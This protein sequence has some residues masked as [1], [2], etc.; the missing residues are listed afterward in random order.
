[1]S[2]IAYRLTFLV[3]VSMKSKTKDIYIKEDR[4]KQH[5]NKMPRKKIVHEVK[6]LYLILF[7]TKRITIIIFE[8][9]VVDKYTVKNYLEYITEHSL[10][11]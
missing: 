8:N 3:I 10:Y 2:A 1:M 4:I 7:L 6:C 9:Y 5:T 11:A